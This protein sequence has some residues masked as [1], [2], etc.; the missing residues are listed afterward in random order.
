[1]I[2]FTSENRP[3]LRTFA[4]PLEESTPANREVSIHIPAVLTIRIIY[5]FSQRENVLALYLGTLVWRIET[6]IN[7]RN[8]RYL[9]LKAI[10]LPAVIFVALFSTVFCKVIAFSVGFL[11]NEFVSS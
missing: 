7:R 11:I 8:I 5:M 2:Q 3:P 10:P 1:M 6:S 4:Y 9:N